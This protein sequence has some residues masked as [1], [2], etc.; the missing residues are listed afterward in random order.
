MAENI[1][2]TTSIVRN[3][4]YSFIRTKNKIINGTIRAV[5]TFKINVTVIN[6]ESAARIIRNAEKTIT[7]RV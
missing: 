7:R 1:V 5:I 3:P 4:K 2:G 6:T